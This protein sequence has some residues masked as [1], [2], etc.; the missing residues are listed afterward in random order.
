MEDVK[1][2]D[3]FKDMDLRYRGVERILEVTKPDAGG[4]RA[5]CTVRVDGKQQKRPTFISRAR[6]CG[7]SSGQPFMR[8]NRPKA[9]PAPKPKATLEPEK[10]VGPMTRAER[11]VLWER[12]RGWKADHPYKRMLRQIDQLEV[13]VE[14][15]QSDAEYFEQRAIAAEMELTKI[16]QGVGTYL[17]SIPARPGQEFKDGRI[18][19]KTRGVVG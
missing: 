1:Q 11:A 2:G 8:I 14:L 5:M 10:N 17:R 7:L 13:A 16:G 4:G 6:L 12:C 9:A 18:V 19:G 3:K 15:A